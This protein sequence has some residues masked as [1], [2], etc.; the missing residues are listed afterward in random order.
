MTSPR[1][2]AALPGNTGYKCTR[3]FIKPFGYSRKNGEKY[4]NTQNKLL[5]IVAAMKVSFSVWRTN[6]KVRNTAW[7]SGKQ[8]KTL[9]EAEFPLSYGKHSVTQVLLV[10]LHRFFFNNE[11]ITS[12]INDSRI[13]KGNQVVLNLLTFPTDH[14]TFQCY[15]DSHSEL[16]SISQ[17][18]TAFCLILSRKSRGLSGT[19]NYCEKEEKTQEN[20][21]KQRTQGSN[22]GSNNLSFLTPFILKHSKALSKLCIQKQLY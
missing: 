12:H 19:E 9:H 10:P 18:R 15:S 1:W 17:A 7:F 13:G 14:S 4:I 21:S 16:V 22:N 5:I 2:K 20:N 11:L 8:S 6:N 3:M